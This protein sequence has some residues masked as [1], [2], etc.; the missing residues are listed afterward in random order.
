MQPEASLHI[1]AD[2]ADIF[3]RLSTSTVS[4]TIQTDGKIIDG[5]NRGSFEVRDGEGTSHTR[6]VNLV[7][8]CILNRMHDFQ[9]RSNATEDGV[10]LVEPWRHSGR[11]EELGT[12]GIWSRICHA[13]GVRPA[14]SKS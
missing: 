2:H 13:Y 3:K 6:L 9:T 11:D 12:I 10:F 5:G 14:M 1:N 7:R 8:S 4:H